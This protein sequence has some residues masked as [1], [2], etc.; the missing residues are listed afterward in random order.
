VQGRVGLGL[1]DSPLLVSVLATW[2]T[3]QTGDMAYNCVAYGGSQKMAD[4]NDAWM[5][6]KESL[7]DQR[8]QFLS[9]YQRD[10]A[11]VQARRFSPR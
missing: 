7:M 5:P 3:L 2:F 6:W 8:L 9:A 11:T 1:L 10:E 4:A